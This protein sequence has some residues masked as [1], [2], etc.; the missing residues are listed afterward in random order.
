MPMIKSARHP[1]IALIAILALSAFQPFSPSAFS[2]D[3]LAFERAEHLRLGV[4]LS[5]WFSSEKDYAIQKLRSRVT[6]DDLRLIRGLGFDHVRLPID[7]KPL[8][9]WLNKEA[10]GIAF[11]G[12]VDKAVKRANELGL[13]VIVDVHPSDEFNKQLEKGGERGEPL[14]KFAALWEALATHFAQTDPKLVFFEILNEPHMTDQNFNWNMH[15]LLAGKIR[16]AAP[17]HT[18]IACPGS[19]KADI[20]GLLDISK[21]LPF[22][23]VIYTFHNYKPDA[24]TH[25]GAGWQTWASYNKEFNHV[26]YP[27]T[28]EN[29]VKSMDQ[30]TSAKGKAIIKKYGEER[31]DA[32]RI[33]REVFAKAEKWCESHGVPAYV[34]EFGVLGGKVDPAMRAQCIHDMRV[35]IQKRHLYGALWDYQTSFGLVTK[36]KGG[37]AVADPAIVNALGLTMPKPA[38]E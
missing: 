29:V 10:D 31:W 16:A 8:Y 2:R 15:K 27:S 17:E 32:D 33:D 34:G 35:A 12:E 30:V 7:A 20:S 1:L 3:A 13:A 26:P 11:M 4:N 5:H 21:L 19:R 6:I 37:K 36:S 9:A 23:N 14:K 24:F 38:G 22:P 28:P 25:Q 18:I